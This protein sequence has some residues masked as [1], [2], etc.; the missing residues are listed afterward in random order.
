MGNILW[1]G[2]Q[3]EWKHNSD[4][5]RQRGNRIL[6]DGEKWD[7]WRSPKTAMESL[8]ICGW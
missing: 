3:V 2:F 8:Q 7:G 6:I 1:I 4:Y 5:L